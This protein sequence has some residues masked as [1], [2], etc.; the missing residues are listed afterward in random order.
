MKQRSSVLVAIAISCLATTAV[1]AESAVAAATAPP[2]PI[3]IQACDGEAPGAAVE[4]SLKGGEIFEGS[5]TMVD[6]RLVAVPVTKIQTLKSENPVP[7]EGTIKPQ[8]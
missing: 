7:A 5:C 1:A 6:G 8:A 2:S 3:V 4:Y